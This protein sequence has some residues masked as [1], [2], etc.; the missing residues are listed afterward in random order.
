MGKTEREG[1]IEWLKVKSSHPLFLKSL[2]SFPTC[3]LLEAEVSAAND[4]HKRN[5]IHYSLKREENYTR[6]ES[7]TR[8]ADS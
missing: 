3:K 6:F 7:S 5:A 4:E 1:L 2:F 8:Q